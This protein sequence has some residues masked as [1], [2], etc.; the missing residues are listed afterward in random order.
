MNKFAHSNRVS[1]EVKEKILGILKKEYPNYFQVLQLE[2]SRLFLYPYKDEVRLD[3][4]FYG[5]IPSINSNFTWKVKGVS[6]TTSLEPSI[7][8]GQEYDEIH[9]FFSSNSSEITLE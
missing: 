3:L 2:N 9:S 1:K 5:R 6:Y 4:G 7:Y 8:A